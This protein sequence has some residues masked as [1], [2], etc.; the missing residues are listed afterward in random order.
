MGS[1]GPDA[2]LDSTKYHFGDMIL[3]PGVRMAKRAYKFTTLSIK[4]AMY[5][6]Y[7]L[8]RRTR[9]ENRPNSHTENTVIKCG[10]GRG[11][12]NLENMELEDFDEIEVWGMFFD[13]VCAMGVRLCRGLD[14]QSTTDQ[15]D[16]HMNEG[17]KEEVKELWITADDVDMQEPYL[18]IGLP[19]CTLFMAI[20]RSFNDTD[21]IV[22]GDSRRIVLQNCPNGFKEMFEMLIVTK[23]S[24]L[25]L[26]SKGIGD[27]LTGK[28]ILWMQQF[29]LYSSSDREMTITEADSPSEERQT[30]LRQA[31][32]H[33]VGVCIQLTQQPYFKE[34][35][36]NVLE[37]IAHQ[38]TSI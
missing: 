8:R 11:G 21:G 26:D 23:N 15:V 3:K 9:V 28:D 7:R 38:V 29:L 24:L 17:Q 14:A 32:S 1:D 6:E 10:G 2:V 19:A 34:N 27:V 37:E 36:M 18:F 13:S 4:P 35:F 16:E 33:L 22:L 30:V 12:D 5:T 20:F 25:E 31:L